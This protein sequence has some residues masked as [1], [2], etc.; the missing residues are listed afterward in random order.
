MHNYIIADCWVKNRNMQIGL[1][2]MFYEVHVTN[3]TAMEYAICTMQYA[4]YLCDITYVCDVMI[5]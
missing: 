3:E 5:A 2:F 4:A 1:M